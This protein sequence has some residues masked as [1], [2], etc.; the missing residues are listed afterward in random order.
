MTRA[1]LRDL[2]ITVGT[3]PTGE[4]NAITDVAGVK[5]GYSTLIRDTPAV[6]RTGVTAIWPRGP[7]IWSDYVF[8]GTFSFNGNGEMTGLPWIAEQGTLGAPIGI[9][10]TYQVGLVRDAICALA[11]RD[12][13]S[14]LFHLPVVAET[15]DG[16][17]S[18]IQSFPL[19]QA[20]ALAALDAATSGAIAEGNVGGGTGMICHEFKGGTGT[21]SRVVSEDGARYTV[22]A[23]V[24]ANYGARDLLRVDGVPIG[25][26]I[27]PDVVPAFRSGG[28]GPA[29]AAT[30]AG[31]SIIVVLATDAPLIP[32][33]CQR[34][35][36]RA[37]TGL[38]WVGGLGANSSGDI[39]IA[40]STANHVGEHDKITQVRML[41]PDA[42]TSLF[43]AAAEATE[44]AILN[45]LCTAETMTG[46]D[47]RTIHALPLDRLQEIMLRAGDALRP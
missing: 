32:V 17:L 40:F 37:T 5:V 39:F 2:G 34:L 1:R 4:F 42:M 38:A 27:G 8:A 36:R 7:E 45:A 25:R 29:A 44:E 43:R 21:A 24:Q 41:A 28:Q 26:M 30:E 14:Q 6:A 11:V 23:L 22:G 35:A 20:H 3:L 47:G 13:A 33:Q 10:N 31:S 9:T 15:Y 46:K 12:G 19:T 18:D 16:W